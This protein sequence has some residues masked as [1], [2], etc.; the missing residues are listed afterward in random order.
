M[1]FKGASRSAAVALAFAA[2]GSCGAGDGSTEP[3]LLKTAITIGGATVQAEL[4]TT[5]AQREQG[6]MQRTA[7]PDTAGMLFVFAG[8]GIREFWM[9][10]TPVNLAIAFLDSSR[11]ILNIDEMKADD[12]TIHRSSGAARYALEV[13]EGWFT[14][15]GISAGT[16]ASFTLPPGLTIDP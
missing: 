10:D 13:R 2:F 6:L 5:L 11:T 4:A 7:L 1:T 3:V 12:L 14:A 8:D 15:H 16:K 9:K